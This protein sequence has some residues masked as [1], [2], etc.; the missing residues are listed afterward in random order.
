MKLNDALC[1]IGAKEWATGGGCTALRFEL[2]NGA[3][4]LLTDDADSNLGDGKSI[5]IGFYDRNG[6]A[7][8][9]FDATV[10]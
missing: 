8:A 3:Y 10:I 7:I 4:A 5:M 9:I 6:E 1:G 2:P